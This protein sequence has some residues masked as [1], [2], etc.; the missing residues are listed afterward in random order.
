GA[1][2][3]GRGAWVKAWEGLRLGRRERQEARWW[4]NSTSVWVR[5]VELGRAPPTHSVIP[6]LDPGIHAASAALAVGGR[7][8][9]SYP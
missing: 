4:S 5:G 7:A 6:G 2:C 3:L 9:A 8:G 1:E